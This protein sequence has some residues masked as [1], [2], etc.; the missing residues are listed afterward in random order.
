[1]RI[2]LPIQIPRQADC[3]HRRENLEITKANATTSRLGR[4]ILRR[5]GAVMNTA[6]ITTQQEKRASTVVLWI[7]NE[8]K[9]SLIND[10][11]GQ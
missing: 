2:T 3:H 4:C 7:R 8:M 1:M 10:L 9:V 11:Q 5:I 6:L